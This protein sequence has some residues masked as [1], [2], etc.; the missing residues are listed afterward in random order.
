MRGRRGNL[1][2]VMGAL[3][4]VGA[5]S[6][7]PTHAVGATKLEH[8]SAGA[9]KPCVVLIEVDGLEPKDVSEATTPFLWA[10]AH[11]SDGATA[12]P[13]T[14]V[15]FAGRHGFMWEAARGVMSSGTAPAAISLL[16]GGGPAQTGV[17]GDAYIKGGLKPG[18]PADV[19][20]L[21]VSGHPIA[22]DDSS[23]DNLLELVDQAGG[24]T[25][26]YVG[27]PAL[28]NA[29][30]IG[31]NTM[32]W[33]PTANGQAST[34]D[35][36]QGNPALC[37][38]PRQPLPWVGD[39]PAAP[40]S[41]PACVASDSTTIHA[42]TDG[43]N[44]ITTKG[45]IP[46]FTYIHLAQLGAV[47][48]LGG[49]DDPS[50][51]ADGQ[52]ETPSAE[53]LQAALS[54]TDAAIAHFVMRV[55]QDPTTGAEWNKTVLMVVGN[56]GYQ[57]TPIADR[58]PDPEAASDPAKDLSD[59]VKSATGGRAVFVPQGTFG[60]IYYPDATVEELAALRD[61]LLGDVNDTC[62]AAAQATPCIGQVYA[63]RACPAPKAKPTGDSAPPADGTTDTT[64]TT[65]A[66]PPPAP[67]HPCIGQLD[68]KGVPQNL[69]EG[70]PVA[71]AGWDIDSVGKDGLPDGTSGDLLVTILAPWAAG[72]AINVDSDNTPVSATRP[73]DATNPYNGSSGGPA[74]RAIAALINGPGEIIRQVGPGSWAA[75]TPAPDKGCTDPTHPNSPT[76]GISPAIANA[77]PGDD[78][79]A[80]GH[81]CQAETI[82]FAPTIAGL[83]E[84]GLAPDQIAPQA[85]FLNESL[86]KPL[87]PPHDEE[88][89]D[90]VPDDVE[91]PPPPPEVIEAPPVVIEE[92]PP[93]PDP[94]PFYGLVRNL[95]ARV[96][97]DR[98]RA[99]TAASPGSLMSS[100][101][102]RGDFGRPQALVTLTFYRVVKPRD[103]QGKVRSS[104]IHLASIA[105]FKPFLLRR[106]PQILTLKIPA[107]F[108]PTY[109]GIAVQEV[110]DTDQVAK[111]TTGG[112]ASVVKSPVGPS[113]GAIVSVSDARH[114]HQRK[115]RKHK[116]TPRPHHK[117]RRG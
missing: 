92:P 24:A 11:T 85:R 60:S 106:G 5:L 52:P 94:F 1:T 93:A 40:D 102:V 89:D 4:A 7:V 64:T 84:V 23:K 81:E 3:A 65:P 107:Q 103:A 10:L 54:A 95:R 78:T 71:P 2:K 82:D 35:Q 30:G 86:I 51:P 115:P 72:R 58:V 108:A 26:A 69:P 111:T 109:I 62:K 41:T 34:P 8:C 27:D 57:S 33:T 18:H 31:D 112:K 75:V 73:P 97:D 25:A 116:A 45:L 100:I 88:L 19:R 17:P 53:A 12:S 117:A 47:K 80:P 90:P 74:N 9:A 83:L 61:K 22:S 99:W 20:R 104:R 28:A 68:A 15:A 110:V 36:D 43:T 39:P 29:V 32:F 42:A 59:Y 96:V 105:R 50:A 87:S 67:A 44:G 56:H 13:V 77:D 101:E 63:T 76:S 113:K 114:L 70:F 49:D 79:Q 66:E 98:R 21:E 6:A 38:L 91:P 55:S 46:E 48:R 37:A 14:S 16:T